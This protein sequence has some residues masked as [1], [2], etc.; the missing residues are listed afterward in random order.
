MIQQLLIA[1]VD[2]HDDTANFH[3]YTACF[4]NITA[5]FNYHTANFHDDTANFHYDTANYTKIQESTDDV[6]MRRVRRTIVAVE[7]R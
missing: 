3:D 2:F 1:I 5:T 6:I 4:H 7:K